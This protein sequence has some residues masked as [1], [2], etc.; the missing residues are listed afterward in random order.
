MKIWKRA[1]I[2]L[3]TLIIA[4]GLVGVMFQQLF[5]SSADETE[6]QRYAVIEVAGEEVARLPLNEN[7]TYTIDREDDMYNVVVIEDGSVYMSEANCPNLNCIRQGKISEVGVPIVCLP[8]Q[9]IVM[10]VE[11]AP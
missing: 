2:V 6:T 11:E 4:V 3:L 9:V 8:H 10:I 5:Q 7:T 1:D